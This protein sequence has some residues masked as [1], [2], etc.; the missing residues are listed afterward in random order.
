MT[1]FYIS[2]KSGLYPRDR[3]PFEEL[4]QGLVVENK[5]TKLFRANSRLNIDKETLNKI[6]NKKNVEKQIKAKEKNLL[7]GNTD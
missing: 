1:L 2:T 5:A 7:K 3:I 4:T 6:Q